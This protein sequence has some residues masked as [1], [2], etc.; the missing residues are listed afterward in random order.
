M[1]GM[2]RQPRG[3][4]VEWARVLAHRPPDLRP[5]VIG[6]FEAAGIEPQHVLGVLSD[7][8]DA[9]YVAALAG[10]DGWTEPF[11]GTIAV[12]LLAAEVSALAAHLNSR[13]S[14]LR[15]VAVNALLDE[16]SAVA[17]SAHLGVSRQKVYEIGRGEITNSY[18]DQTPWRRA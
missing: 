9:L 6:R 10:G 14:A 2:G 3:D 8:G 18:I 17:V 5:D 12:A 1:Y 16:Y 4:K 13:A 11:G 7:A 15:A